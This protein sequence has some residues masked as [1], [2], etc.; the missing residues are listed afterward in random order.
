[1]P[2]YQIKWPLKYPN[3]ISS[4]VDFPNLTRGLLDRGY[5][6]SDVKKIMG[7][8]FLRLFKEVWC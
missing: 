7:E 8:N 3:G 5:S 1:E 4:A 2:H 6:E